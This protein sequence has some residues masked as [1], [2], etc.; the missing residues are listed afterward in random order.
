MYEA[1]ARETKRLTWKPQPSMVSLTRW[2]DI[3]PWTHVQGSHTVFTKPV[4]MTIP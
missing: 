2:I 1:A 3:S 4:E